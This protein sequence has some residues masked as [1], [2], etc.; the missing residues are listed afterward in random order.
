MCGRYKITKPI[1]KTIDLIK[2]NI[3]V[4]NIDNYNAHPSQKLPIIKS[5]T[6]GK[7]LELYEWGLIPEW[8]KKL[9][10]FS[11][12]INARKETLIEKVT[13]KNLIQTSRCLVLADGYYEWKRKEKNK[14][15]YYFTKENDELMFLAAIHQNNQFCIITR[16][17][18]EE[19]SEIHHR[20]PLIVNQSQIN[21]YLNVKKDAMEV[22]NSIKPPKL[23]FHEITKDVNNPANNDSSLISKLN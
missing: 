16:E 4:E 21:N 11:P 14:I 7:T 19:I 10:K 5:Y 9:E 13:F 8:S 22:L 23:K 3:K 18:T 2:T 6:N 20:E 17:A 15:P 12:L 1:T